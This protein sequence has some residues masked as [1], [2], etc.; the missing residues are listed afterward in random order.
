MI[1]HAIASVS[2]RRLRYS[3]SDNDSPSTKVVYL[4][5]LLELGGYEDKKNEIFPETFHLSGAHLFLGFSLRKHHLSI[6]WYPTFP[7]NRLHY[8]PVSF[9]LGHYQYWTGGQARQMKSFTISIEKLIN[10]LGSYSYILLLKTKLYK[11]KLHIAV[12]NKADKLQL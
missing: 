9:C 10:R 3:H 1:L 7:P 2:P 11:E 4:A 5:I 8:L 6:S 12:K